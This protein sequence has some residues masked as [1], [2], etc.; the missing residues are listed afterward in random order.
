[1]FYLYSGLGQVGHHG[2]MLPH[3]D[4]RVV[5]LGEGLLEGAQLLVGERRPAASL[6]PMSAITRLQMMSVRKYQYVRSVVIYALPELGEGGWP[7]HWIYGSPIQD[8]IAH[9]CIGSV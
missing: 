8:K 3:D 5:R 4:I 9:F 6:L 2:E 1:M 7:V